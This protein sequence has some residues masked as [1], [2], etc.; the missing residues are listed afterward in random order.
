MT[1]NEEHDAFRWIQR[2]HLDREFLWPGERNQ[3]GELCREI[4]DE[5]PAKRYLRI[6]LP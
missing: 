6:S 2:P 1:L 5:G 4:L 3:L